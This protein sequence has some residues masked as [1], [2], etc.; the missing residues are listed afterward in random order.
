MRE[1]NNEERQDTDTVSAT[2]W[3]GFGE[4]ILC[5]VLSPFMM[6]LLTPSPS[7]PPTHCSSS[8]FTRPTR[9]NPSQASFTAFVMQL[10]LLAVALA[11]AV[12]M[13]SAYPVKADTLN[14]RS[15]P[16]TSY[17]V[18]K[19]Y[20]KNDDVKITCQ[21]PGTSVEGD[22]LWLPEADHP[23]S[24]RRGRRRRQRAGHALSGHA[25]FCVE[26]RFSAGLVAG[27]VDDLLRHCLG[28]ELRERAEKGKLLLD[29][30][31]PG[32]YHLLVIALINAQEGLHRETV[33]A[34][35][36]HRVA[37]DPE[38]DI[39]PAENLIRHVYPIVHSAA[40]PTFL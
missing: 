10:S 21:T 19:T 32:R 12:P 3:R 34:A 38:I 27:L 1:G 16:G 23:Y 29:E 31:E 9:T 15:G 40:H 26:V 13:V 4:Y 8:H 39:L 35:V 30:G 33:S 36:A 18:V 17:K 2:A 28:E 5:E 22:N 11:A 7:L 6:F 37:P 20:K 24:S 25:K 14:C